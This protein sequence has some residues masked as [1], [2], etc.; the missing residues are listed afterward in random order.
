M[1]QHIVH[2]LMLTR[3][4]VLAGG[5]SAASSSSSSVLSDTE[6]R[7]QRQRLLRWDYLPKIIIEETQAEI[8]AC[9]VRRV[10]SATYSNWQAVGQTYLPPLHHSQAE[11]PAEEDREMQVAPSVGSEVSISSAIWPE[12]NCNLCSEL[13]PGEAERAFLR[14]CLRVAELPNAPDPS[15]PHPIRSP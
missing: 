6:L 9:M 8:E 13:T 12:L 10:P 14:S 11:A 2:A 4:K 15:C 7:R 5:S 3:P 1:G